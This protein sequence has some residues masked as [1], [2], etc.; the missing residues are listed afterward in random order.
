MARIRPTQ[1]TEPV[2][3]SFKRYF[4]PMVDT[5]GQLHSREAR[6]AFVLEDQQGQVPDEVCQGHK[7][8]TANGIH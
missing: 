6:P 1:I 7:V 2:R 4:L 8:F 5:E 3:Y